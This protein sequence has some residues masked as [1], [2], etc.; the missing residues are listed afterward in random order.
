M[1]NLKYALLSRRLA[2]P[3]NAWHGEPP[4][5][6]YWLFLFAIRM[7]PN[8][9]THQL[10]Y[11]NFLESC[12]YL[13]SYFLTSSNDA[14]WINCSLSAISRWSF[15]ISKQPFLSSRRKA[16]RHITLFNVVIRLAIT[17]NKI[18]PYIIVRNRPTVRRFM[19]GGYTLNIFRQYPR[20]FPFKKQFDFLLWSLLRN[21]VFRAVDTST[22]AVSSSFSS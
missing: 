11:F 5:S 8:H 15:C 19:I 9:R 6:I 7:F 1:E 17:A 21:R 16:R 22:V 3:S 4:M 13:A 18:F 2:F 10:N 12:L 20:G 14:G